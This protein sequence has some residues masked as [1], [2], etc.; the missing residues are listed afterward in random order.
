MITTRI[1]AWGAIMLG[2]LLVACGSPAARPAAQTGQPVEL[3][4][5]ISGSPELDAAMNKVLSAFAAEHPDVKPV[6]EDFPFNQYYTKLATAFAGGAA[7]D[8]F[9][10][11]IRTAEFAKRG[12]LLP[13]DRYV[14]GDWTADVYPIALQEGEWNG[15][16]YSVPMH[17]LANGLFVNAALFEEA[18]IPVPQQVQDAWTWE[19]LRSYAVRL[20]E[21][22]GS[23][24]T[25]WGF[26]SQRDP[27]DW[28]V[29]P[30]LHQNGGRALSPD[31][32]H[33]VGFLDA[34][35]SV[36]ALQFYGRLY[37]EDRA[38]SASLPPDALPNGKV[39]IFDAVSTYVIPL[40]QRFPNFRY[41]V[42]PAPRNSRCAVMTGGFNV[43]ISSSTRQ[44]DL[45]WSLVDYMTRVKHAQWAEDSGY[46]PD[47]RS[48]VAANPMYQQQPWKLFLD[49]L[50]QCAIHRPATAEYSFFSDV[51]GD[52]AKDITT[53]ANPRAAAER[54]AR[55]LEPRLAAN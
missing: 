53:G 9:W 45:A 13:L 46:L 7:P 27:G 29:L 19:Q 44:P 18:G 20:T 35:E 12:A 15:R 42:A 16:R 55:I 47:R 36:A 2:L 6:L 26:G 49:E 50:D 39:A 48:A 40:K 1:R 54:A 37:T 31:D 38:A 32:R 8:I 33:A 24:T 17:E 43:G 10:I 41:A 34:P 30:Y 4:V 23:A 28:T 5:W 14:T 11:D 21:R 22:S 25:R 52:M 51:F 3:R